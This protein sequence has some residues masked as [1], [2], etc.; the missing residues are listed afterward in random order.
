MHFTHSF[1]SCPLIRVH[2]FLTLFAHPC[3]S[4][5]TQVE[6]ANADDPPA[7]ATLCRAAEKPHSHPLAG[8]PVTC[9]DIFHSCAHY[10]SLRPCAPTGRGGQRGRPATAAA[11]CRAAEKPCRRAH[12]HG[13]PCPPAHGPPIRALWHARSRG[14]DGCATTTCSSNQSSCYPPR[15]CP[16]SSNRSSSST[17][18]GTSS[19]SYKPSRSDASSRSS[20]GRAC[21]GLTGCCCCAGAAG[22]DGG[23][24]GRAWT[25][26]PW[27]PTSARCVTINS[28]AC[29][30]QC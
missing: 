12:T 28:N 9:I 24:Y 13:R 5:S 19:F 17:S 18:R 29:R 20:R 2:A 30:K 21:A 11:L 1:I 8:C 15:S 4:T 10:S 6:E 22:T 7:A 25:T 16:S 23:D 27:G 14:G 3:A 26:R